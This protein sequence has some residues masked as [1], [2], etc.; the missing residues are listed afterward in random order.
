MRIL[1]QDRKAGN[2]RLRVENTDD[3][4]HLYNLIRAG[5][6]V[7]SLTQRREEKAG[8]KIREKRG[9][10]RTLYL[11]IQVENVEFHEFADRLRVSGVILPE[12]QD[13]GS[14]HTLNIE[15]GTE[16]ELIK[17]RWLPQDIRRLKEAEE[18]GKK[19]R[20]IVVSLDE[21]EATVAVLRGYGIQPAGTVQSGRS[22]KQY[23]SKSTKEDYFRGIVSVISQI[24]N[25]MP[26]LIAG[27]GFTKEEFLRF[28]RVRFPE[29]FEKAVAVSTGQT[30]MP[31][32]NEVL[33]SGAVSQV[34]EGTRLEYE[35]QLMERFLKEL[36][37]GEKAAYGL[38]EVKDAVK[39]GAV[40]ELLVTDRTLREHREET[41]RLLKS[42]EK[43]GAEIAVISEAHDAG[44]QL[45]S[46]GG[47]AAILRYRIRG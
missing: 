46:L 29:V 6:R 5:D 34:A 9:E 43:S 36:S 4:W 40:E 25:G 18:S 27:P 15:E 23:S 1:H 2:I 14:H 33:K 13:A 38:R 39:A 7:F 30:G 28:G 44:R 10:K 20:V 35:A 45:Q 8:D 37:T 16:L 31:G 41:A 12:Q 21:D 24:G 3:L 42:A 26:L 17:N 11:G 32:I 47:Y 19:P 22:G